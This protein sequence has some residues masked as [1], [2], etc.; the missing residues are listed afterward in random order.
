MFIKE[1][2]PKIIKNSRG[3]N[4]IEVIVKTLKDNFSASAPSGKSKGKYETQDFNEKGINFSLRLLNEFCALLKNRNLIFKKFDDLK[5]I[6]ESI[7]AF[8]NEF[9]KLGANTTYALETALLKAASK[10][11]EKELWEFILENKKLQVP[12]PIGNCIGGG[13]HTHSNKKPDFQEFLLIPNEKTFSKAFTKMFKAYE[14]AKREIKAVEKRWTIQTNDEK[15]WQT[16]L[17]NEICLDILRL[18]ADKYGLR[19]GIDMASSTFFNDNK[20]EYF[21][22]NKEIIRDKESHLEYINILIQRYNLFYVEDPVNEEDFL[23]FSRLISFKNSDALIVGDD[24]TATHLERIKKASLHKSINAVIIKPN[25]NGYLMQVKEIVEFCKKNNIKI[26]FSHRSGETMDDSLADL[27]IG[28]QADFIKIGINGKE[29]LIKLRRIIEI[30]K[31]VGL[32]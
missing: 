15:A 9:G 14:T 19:I 32:G 29:R 1:V 22:K 5:N 25:Q 23:G 2:N 28:F 30:E 10:E 11:N 6:E 18:V 24:L 4:T 16:E 12:M 17:S 13:M 7:K 3:E 31:S 27:A 21:Y 20:K 26:V 8:E